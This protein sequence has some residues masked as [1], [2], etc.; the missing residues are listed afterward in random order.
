[1][2][3]TK[4]EAKNDIAYVSNGIKSASYTK[5]TKAH[6]LLP[7][8]MFPIQNTNYKHHRHNEIQCRKCETGLTASKLFTT[9]QNQ[10]YI[11]EICI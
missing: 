7:S 10:W 1:M 5:S 9:P 3:K 6:Y 2:K 4:H 11:K 8:C